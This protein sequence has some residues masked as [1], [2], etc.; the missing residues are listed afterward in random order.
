MTLKKNLRLGDRVRL[1]WPDGDQAVGI[2]QRQE[3]GYAVLLVEGAQV[4]GA[5]ASLKDIE[6]LQGSG[7]IQGNEDN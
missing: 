2:F 3:R 7:S 5:L 6:I 4:V 1:T